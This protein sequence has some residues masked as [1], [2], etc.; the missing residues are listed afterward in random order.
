[1]RTARRR[2]RWECRLLLLVD[3]RFASLFSQ[4]REAT[5]HR[6]RATYNLTPRVEPVEAEP[7]DLA[8]VRAEI[9]L[10]DRELIYLIGRRAALCRMAG[11]AKRA[12]GKPV[13]DMAQEAAVV[14]RA[15]GWAREAEVPEE[16]ARHIMWRLIHLCRGVQM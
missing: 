15:A 3:C 7:C 10:L 8:S 5:P 1:M 9:A 4:P 16:D 13:V 2:S 6:D 14:R 12:L 11:T